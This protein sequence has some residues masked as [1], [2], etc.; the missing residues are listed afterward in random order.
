MFL[1]AI[2]SYSKYLGLVLK[3]MKHLYLNKQYFTLG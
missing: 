3:W 2:I 1:E